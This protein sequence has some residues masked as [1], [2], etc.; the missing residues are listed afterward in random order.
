MSSTDH[1]SELESLRLQVADLP[2]ELAGPCGA[3]LAGALRELCR[4]HVPKAAD[5][6]TCASRRLLREMSALTRR[7]RDPELR[8]RRS[9]T[10]RSVSLT[11][12]HFPHETIWSES[13]A[14][15]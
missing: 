1:L 15:M 9:V 13:H 4:Q 5:L 10:L 11:S 6:T 3:G 2:R 12:P 8:I 7:L 14:P